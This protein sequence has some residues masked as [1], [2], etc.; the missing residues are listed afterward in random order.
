MML[1][2]PAWHCLQHPLVVAGPGT[3]RPGHS[4][5]QINV[6]LQFEPEPETPASIT[7]FRLQQF[8]A[9]LHYREST[10]D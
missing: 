2:S 8:P 6:G 3:V 9:A 1:A 7:V 5:E 10:I 4:Q